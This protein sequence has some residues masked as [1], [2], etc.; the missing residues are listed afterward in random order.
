MGN[1]Q[2]L[3]PPPSPELAR[4]MGAKGGK[5][6][7]ESKRKKRL[8]SQIYAAFLAEKF[9]VR[10]DG[11][12]EQI[13]GEKLVDRVIKQV[14]ITGGSSA[15]S[16]MKEIREATEGS[17]VYSEIDLPPLVINLPADPGREGDSVGL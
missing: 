10:I 9:K 13:T 6:A 5:A 8:M 14:L 3:R 15:V 2:N 7:A 16:L 11:A 1:P 17:K 12:D 4:E